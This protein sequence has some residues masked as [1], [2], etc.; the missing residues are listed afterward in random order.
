MPNGLIQELATAVVHRFIGYN[1]SGKKDANK[2]SEAKLYFLWAMRA[3]VK[4][5]SMT[6]LQDCLQEIALNQRGILAL[7]HVVTALAKHFR[8]PAQP[9]FIDATWSVEGAPMQCL[10]E[11][12]LRQADLI[13]NRTTP[14]EYT[15]R[16]VYDIYFKKIKGNEAVNTN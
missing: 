10:N 16:K 15:K 5:C 12:E 7:G 6:F 4:V 9:V 8:I 14:Q 13:Q 11:H 2:V 1:I 3:G